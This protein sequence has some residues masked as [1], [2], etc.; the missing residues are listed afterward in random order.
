MPKRRRNKRP[1]R[2]RRKRSRY[3]SYG[4]ANPRAELKV[5]YIDFGFTSLGDQTNGLYTSI[6]I[7]ST[8]SGLSHRIGHRICAKSI[9]WKVTIKQDS[10]TN[11]LTKPN[12]VAVYLVWDKQV[13][14]T[15]YAAAALKAALLKSSANA[16]EGLN[17]A[18]RDRFRVLRHWEFTLHPQ[19]RPIVSRSKFLKLNNKE[20][21]YN[22]DTTSDESTISTNNLF[23]YALSLSSEAAGVLLFKTTATFRYTDA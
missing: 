6:P 7:I 9:D 8:G 12:Y 16:M 10:T 2:G 3:A 1:L 15:A 11:P 4:F 23:V 21:T 20:I 18:Y 17:L 22:G 14:N 5:K 13:N 19:A